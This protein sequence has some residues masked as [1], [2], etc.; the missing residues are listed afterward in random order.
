MLMIMPTK[1]NTHSHTD[2]VNVEIGKRQ[3]C[4]WWNS[5]LHWGTVGRQVGRWAVEQLLCPVAVNELVIQ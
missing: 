2:E 1:V 5:G 4:G 3:C